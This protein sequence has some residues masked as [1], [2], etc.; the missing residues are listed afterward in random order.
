LIVLMIDLWNLWNLENH[1]HPAFFHLLLL[2]KSD[3]GMA[4]QLKSP[5]D[6]W[7]R[8]HGGEGAE[9]EAIL[10][11]LVA[12]EVDAEKCAAGMVVWR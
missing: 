11:P 6:H 2:K 7:V 3:L 12:M 8:V 10:C 9:C 5:P 1:N 4:K